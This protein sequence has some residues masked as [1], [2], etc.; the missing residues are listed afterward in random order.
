M[1][2]QCALDCHPA[3]DAGSASPVAECFPVN[4]PGSP[5]PAGALLGRDDELRGAGVLPLRRPGL[6]PGPAANWESL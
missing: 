3:L 1:L 5:V 4:H 2:L 6:E